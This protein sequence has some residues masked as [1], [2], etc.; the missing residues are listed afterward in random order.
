MAKDIL[1]YGEIHS[2]SAQEFITKMDEL[3]GESIAVRVNTNGGEPSYGWGMVAKFSEHEGQKLV[4]VDGKAYSFGLF[5]L[6]YSEYSEALDVSEFLIHRA[7]YPEWME[8]NPEYFTDELRGNLSRIN[9]SLEKAFRN[10]VDVE[11]FEKI[12]GVKVS[13]IFS[14]DARLDV[15]LT[16]AEAKRIGLISRV[17]PITPTKKTEIDTAML[18][19]A[20]KYSGVKM[21]A[22]SE[23]TSLE[24]AQNSKLIK[25]KPTSMT[26]EELKAQ[27][28][29]LCAQLVAEGEKKGEEKE[30]ERVKAWLQFSDVDAE[31]VNKGINEGKEIS[32]SVMAE[33]TRKGM[34]VN[35]LG[36]IKKDNANGVQTTEV[37]EKEKNEKEKAVS[38]FEEEVKA[39]LGMDVKS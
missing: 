11:L 13:D 14:M 12:K 9:K 25:P 20:A 21:A 15:F 1:L 5:F 33:F 24:D 22:L 37:T 10:K 26:L 23:T 17:V 27:H 35:A 34:N 29:A 36:A 16:A 31:A 6:C 7:A 4:K 18:R 28:P 3:A 30:R 19:I 2:W 32:I 38:S 8:R 39:N